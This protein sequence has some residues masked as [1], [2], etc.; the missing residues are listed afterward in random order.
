MTHIHQ[1]HQTAAHGVIFIFI[2]KTRNGCV[3]VHP[4]SPAALSVNIKAT[5]IIKALN[6]S[7]TELLSDFVPSSQMSI[8]QGRQQP[9]KTVQEI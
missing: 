3:C 6:E 9:K 1:F 2:V 8:L 5:Y 4:K 7:D